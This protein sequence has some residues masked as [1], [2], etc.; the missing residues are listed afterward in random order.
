MQ[1]IGF[2]QLELNP[3]TV[4]GR[5]S[6]LLTAGSISDWNTMTAGWGTLGY[7][8]EAPVATVFVR[9]SRYTLSFM[10][11]YPR[12]TLSFF[13]PEHAKA[14]EFCGANSGRT[15]DKAAGAGITPIG[16]GGSVAFAEANLVFV[17]QKMSETL[18][19]RSSMIDERILPLYPQ[20][21]WHRMF[22]GRIEGVY[23]P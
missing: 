4:I 6:F 1:E 2:E 15:A 8:W 17:C 5:D 13:P 3:F 23:I 12:F 22:V 11:R 14:L 21:D 9:G 7:L 10:E 16:L 18:I 20:G 19:D